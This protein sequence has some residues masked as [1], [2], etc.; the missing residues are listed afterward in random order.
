MLEQRLIEIMVK[1]EELMEDLTLLRELNLSNSWIA[2]GYVRNYCWDILHGYNQ[3]TLLEDVDIIYY[4][5]SD[6]SFDKEIEY[7]KQLIIK[8]PRHNW[9]VKNQARMHI[10]NKSKPYADIA[11]AMRHWPETAT[12]VGIRMDWDNQIH[13]MAPLG[14]EDLFDLN[15]RKSSNFQNIDYFHNRIKSKKWLHKWPKLRIIE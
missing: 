1:N 9:S 11:D 2:A 13:I 4:D 10:T 8:K 7:E 14:L 5:S 3:K 15:I 12:A 6:L